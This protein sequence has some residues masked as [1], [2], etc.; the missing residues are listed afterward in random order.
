MKKKILVVDDDQTILDV[1]K[2]NLKKN[3]YRVVVAM[4][5][6]EAINLAKSEKP[7]LVVLDI[8]L[9]VLDGF[10]VCRI[11]RKESEVPILMLTAKSDEVDK[12][13]ALGLGADDYIVKPFSIKE[14]LTRIRV[15]LRR[16]QWF[17]PQIPSDKA[18]Q[19]SKMRAG[20]LEIDL[21][22]YQVLNDGLPVKLRRKEF[23]LLSFLLRNKGVVFNRDQLLERIWGED[24]DGYARTVDVHIR[25]LRK[26]IEPDPARPK[27]VI[28]IHG[29]G[30]KFDQ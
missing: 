27:H 18:F 5:G 11:L 4:N 1:L 25:S 13:L 7:D 9:P 20:N 21:A 29:F 17:G 2:Y 28:T 10:E 16:Q 30:Y 26:K 22:K 19:P 23:Q 12:V 6:E 24:Y 15:R 3:G 14:L 8:M